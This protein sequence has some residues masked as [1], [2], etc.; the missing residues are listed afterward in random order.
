MSYNPVSHN[1]S[2]H[3]ALDYHFVRE[4]VAAGHLR[5]QFVPSAFQIADLFTKSLSRPQFLFFCSKLNV[6]SPTLSLREGVKTNKETIHS[7]YKES[8]PALDPDQYGKT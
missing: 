2:K 4:K 5:V 8:L 1:R 7:S 6:S 3:I